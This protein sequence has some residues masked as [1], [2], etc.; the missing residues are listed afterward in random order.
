[1]SMADYYQDQE[2]D[3]LVAYDN[4]AAREE[5]ITQAKLLEKRIERLIK[6]QMGIIKSEIIAANNKRWI[7][8]VEKTFDNIFN[9]AYGT[10]DCGR[11]PTE[12]K[13]ACSYDRWQSL[14]KELEVK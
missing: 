11:C 12:F 4:K 13:G 14:K 3:A 2:M 9:C 6:K 10:I 8:T 7:E 1:M 5:E